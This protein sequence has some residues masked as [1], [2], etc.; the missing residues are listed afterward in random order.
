MSLVL[1]AERGGEGRGGEG[2][3]GERSGGKRGEEGGEGNEVI[4]C[5][6]LVYTDQ[7]LTSSST[8]LSLP[9]SCRERECAIKKCC[10]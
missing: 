4:I 7:S 5:P 10:S 3:G 1:A 6:A 9:F 2:R 8:G